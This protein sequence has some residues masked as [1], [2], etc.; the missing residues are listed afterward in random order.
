MRMTVLRLDAI[1]TAEEKK[2]RDNLTIFS[3]FDE[4]FGD[5]AI[6]DDPWKIAGLKAV[7]G[8]NVVGGCGEDKAQVIAAALQRPI[9]R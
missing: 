8:T 3:G 9:R 4:C 6:I 7:A 1:W 5:F 2:I